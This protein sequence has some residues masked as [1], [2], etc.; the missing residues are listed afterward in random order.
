MK[1]GMENIPNVIDGEAVSVSDMSETVWRVEKRGPFASFVVV[2][3]GVDDDSVIGFEEDCSSLVEGEDDGGEDICCQ[4][5]NV[6]EY[7]VGRRKC[8]SLSQ[9]IC[10]VFTTLEKLEDRVN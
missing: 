9:L 8:I 5:W 2:V 10:N 6:K 4:D 7:M 3:V 1:N